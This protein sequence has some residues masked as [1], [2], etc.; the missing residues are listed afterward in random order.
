MLYDNPVIVDIRDK[1]PLSVRSELDVVRIIEGR[2]AHT[3][4]LD[5]EGLHLRRTR[6]RDHTQKR[7]TALSISSLPNVSISRDRVLR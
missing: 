2:R 6:Q 3:E 1:K 5:T 7:A 4:E